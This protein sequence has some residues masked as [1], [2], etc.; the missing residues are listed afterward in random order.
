MKKNISNV[1]LFANTVIKVS[2]FL[3][4]AE[5]SIRSGKCRSKS[6]GLAKYE[7]I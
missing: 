2:Q 1:F 7:H 4:S 3:L 5:L 6:K